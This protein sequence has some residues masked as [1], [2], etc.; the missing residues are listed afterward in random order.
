MLLPNE[1]EAD[2]FISALS[3]TYARLADVQELHDLVLVRY[4]LLYVLHLLNVIQTGSMLITGTR[5]VPL[6]IRRMVPLRLL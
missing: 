3:A 4:R 1:K 6:R 5:I 2:A